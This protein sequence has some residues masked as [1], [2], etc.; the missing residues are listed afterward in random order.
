MNASLPVSD[1][2]TVAG[3]VNMSF[4]KYV[5]GCE[6]QTVFVCQLTKALQTWV[7]ELPIAGDRTRKELTDLASDQDRHPYRQQPPADLL[8]TRLVSVLPHQTDRYTT[9]GVDFY[10]N[11]YAPSHKL[12]VTLRDGSNGLLTRLLPWALQDSLI[13]DAVLAESLATAADG[14][15]NCEFG[16]SSLVHRDSAIAQMLDRLQTRCDHSVVQAVI[17]LVFTDVGS[18][19]SIELR[20]LKANSSKEASWEHGSRPNTSS[21]P[22]RHDPC[23]WRSRQPRLRWYAKRHHTHVRRQSL[24]P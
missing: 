13:L 14:D 22:S 2:N 3:R 5:L 18:H 16:R 6:V 8:S 19:L 1:A 21:W 20:C 9:L 11:Q 10:I 24:H 12:L 4:Q 15:L 17:C 7:F 23:L